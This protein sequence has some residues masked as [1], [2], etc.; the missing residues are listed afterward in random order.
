MESGHHEGRLRRSDTDGFGA[1]PN[2]AVLTGA[3]ERLQPTFPLLFGAPMGD[4]L[5]RGPLPTERAG[6][7]VLLPTGDV[8]AHASGHPEHSE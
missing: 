6:T 4:V 1:D 5:R 8:V 2:Y 3:D 7:S